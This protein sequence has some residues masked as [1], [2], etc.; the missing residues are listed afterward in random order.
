MQDT[1]HFRYGKSEILD[2]I[3]IDLILLFGK[4]DVNRCSLFR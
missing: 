2:L 3:G 4:G 1:V